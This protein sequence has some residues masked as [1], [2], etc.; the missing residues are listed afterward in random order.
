MH[1]VLLACV[2]NGPCM[3]RWTCVRSTLD[4]SYVCAMCALCVRYVCA[5]CALDLSLRTC[6]E[7]P[8]CAPRVSGVGPAHSANLWRPSG[9]YTH[10][11]SSTHKNSEAYS[12]CI[13]LVQCAQRTSNEC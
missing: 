1:S 6:N 9:V 3:Q 2:T 8:A 5:R 4:V 13:A 10:V 11:S 7:Y 12:A